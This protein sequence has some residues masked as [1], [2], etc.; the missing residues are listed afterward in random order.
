MTLG[1]VVYQFS[2]QSVSGLVSEISLSLSVCVLASFICNSDPVQRIKIS[3]L[4]GTC[5]SRMAND[6]Q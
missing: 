5:F 2:L 4:I 6:Q 3:S 1:K